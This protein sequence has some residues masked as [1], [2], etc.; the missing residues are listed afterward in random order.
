MIKEYEEY[1]EKLKKT[2]FLW[3]FLAQTSK[4]HHRFYGSWTACITLDSLGKMECGLSLL[5]LRKRV[6]FNLDFQ[7]VLIVFK[8]RA[9][10]KCEYQKV[11]KL[12]DM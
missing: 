4:N 6:M 8:E 12:S 9:E 11:D 5:R 2:G 10:M 7:N 3:F 1:K